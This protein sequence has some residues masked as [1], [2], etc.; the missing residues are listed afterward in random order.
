M[1]QDSII[2]IV[3]SVMGVPVY[4]IT[5]T[6][7]YKWPVV[8]HARWIIWEHYYETKKR[9]YSEIGRQFK[10]DHTTVR[11]GI[12]K[13]PSL[14]AQDEALA[15]QYDEVRR[16]YNS[17]LKKSYSVFDGTYRGHARLC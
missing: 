15:F 3:S 1:R 4:A 6:T 17:S 8:S 5:D 13:L 9:S 10:C 11:T 16:R 7:N 2:Q 12:I 14:L